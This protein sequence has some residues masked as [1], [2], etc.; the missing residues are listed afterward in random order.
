MP[1]WSAGLSRP[2]RQIWITTLCMN[3]SLTVH[4]DRQLHQDLSEALDWLDANN[5]S[6]DGPMLP[7]L[8]QKWLRLAITS[9]QPTKP[10]Q[11]EFNELYGQQF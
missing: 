10:H 7:S 8:L 3:G 5:D 1:S 4:G 11:S 6:L 2:Q 9:S